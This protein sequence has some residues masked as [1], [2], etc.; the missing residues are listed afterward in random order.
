MTNRIFSLPSGRSVVLKAPSLDALSELHGL[1]TFFNDRVA[2]DIEADRIKRDFMIHGM[3]KFQTSTPQ[4]REFINGNV[5]IRKQIRP[6][7]V[8]ETPEQF[9]TESQG[10]TN[11]SYIPGLAL[12]LRG[13]RDLFSPQA[14][15][16]LNVLNRLLDPTSHITG[17]LTPFLYACDKETPPRVIFSN[18]LDSF[19]RKAKKLKI[20][21][22]PHKNRVA[23]CGSLVDMLKRLSP[24]HDF[25]H[26]NHVSEQPP[27][28]HYMS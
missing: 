16:R 23:T 28:K 9:Y 11:D 13:V 24:K 19:N 12:D 2:K 20:G 10:E 17:T 21:N 22:K 26:S 4:M 27:T 5:L 25:H 6:G 15:A 3:D 8:A 7:V 18:S 14:R 1:K